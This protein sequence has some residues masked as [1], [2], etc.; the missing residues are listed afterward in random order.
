M[1]AVE[2]QSGLI[3]IW[4]GL[5]PFRKGIAILEDAEK[6]IEGTGTLSQTA[7]DAVLAQLELARTRGVNHLKLEIENNGSASEGKIDAQFVACM[8][9][10]K[11]ELQNYYDVFSEV[12]NK[13][14]AILF[15]D[16]AIPPEAEMNRNFRYDNKLQKKFA[17]S[18]QQ[19][20]ECQERRRAAERETFGGHP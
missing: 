1:I 7:H 16:N 20:L 8:K 17:Y 2:W 13:D 9:E 14:M 5:E 11:K 19:L 12:L 18:R 6:E 3:R 10:A 15:A 4:E